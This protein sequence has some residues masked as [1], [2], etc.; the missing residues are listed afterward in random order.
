MII[1]YIYNVRISG[2]LEKIE[3]FE[4]LVNVSRKSQII[5]DTFRHFRVNR[6][7]R[8]AF[9]N[10]SR[11]MLESNQR[12]ASYIISNTSIISHNTE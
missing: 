10:R 7:G 5:L 4:V 3:A 2:N 6:G 1:V 11:I 12:T 8:S 9:A